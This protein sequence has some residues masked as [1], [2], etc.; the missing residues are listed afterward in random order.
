HPV[1]LVPEGFAE[2]H[3][4]EAIFQGFR[5]YEWTASEAALEDAGE[6]RIFWKTCESLPSNLLVLDTPDIDSDA[7]I[8]WQRAD[9]IRRCADV[10]IAVLTQQKYNDA[11][12]K[13]FFRKA[14]AEDKAVIAV[15]NQLQLPY[16]E[17]Y[18]PLWLE[19]FTAETGIDPEVVYVAPVNRQAAEDNRLGFFERDW[20]AAS[21]RE[22]EEGA[23]PQAAPRQHSA[24]STQHSAL[25]T[26]SDLAQDLSRLK[27]A[28]IKLRTLRG[29]LEHLLD[30]RGGVPAYLEEIRRRSAEF[31]AA[32][33]RLSSE[34][35]VKVRDWPSVPANL[36]VAEIRTWWKQQHSGWAKT[37]HGVYDSVG[38]GMLWPFRFARDQLAGPKPS[39]MEAYRE[40][41]WSAILRAVE[42]IYDK[43]SWMSES[44]NV[45]LRPSFERLV[46]GRS[47]QE[48]LDTL[49]REHKQ[50]DLDRELETSVAREMKT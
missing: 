38:K 26:H 11:A 30:S 41:E 9:H 6:H 34:S 35:V 44:G 19:T 32:A 27:F 16:D 43:L 22:R 29:S 15:F 50:V 2:S 49:R 18:W 8:N 40:R 21:V 45:L 47:R 23:S 5:L 20:P 39:P 46:A 12:V 14:A 48:L 13:E 7:R 4:L 1:C 3:D 28:E 31:A 42:E 24:L 25:S 36:L 10:L 37:V 17:G 33:E